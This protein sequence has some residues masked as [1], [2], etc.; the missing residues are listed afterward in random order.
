MHGVFQCK[1]TCML[2]GL[3]PSFRAS[4]GFAARARVC[5]PPTKPEEKERLLAVYENPRIQS[6]LKRL[7]FKLD[8][9][10]GKNNTRCLADG[11]RNGL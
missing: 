9:Y 4:R 1:E 11:S 2:H 3:P 8:A 5:T 10:P 7:K 6:N